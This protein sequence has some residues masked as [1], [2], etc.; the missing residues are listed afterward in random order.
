VEQEEQSPRKPGWPAMGVTQQ[1]PERDRYIYPRE[2]MLDRLAVMMGG[3]G[4]GGA[5]VRHDD[6]RRRE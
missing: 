6:Q 3:A 5:G 2:Y 4:G 1:L